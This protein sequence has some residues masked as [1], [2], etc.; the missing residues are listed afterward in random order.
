MFVSFAYGVSLRRLLRYSLMLLSLVAITSGSSQAEPAAPLLEMHYFWGDGCPYCA[1]QDRWLEDIERHYPQLVVH[2][3]EVWNNRANLQLFQQFAATRGMEARGVP[4]TF[5]GSEVWIGFSEQIADEMETSIR[6]RL[7]AAEQGVLETDEEPAALG[8]ASQQLSLPWIG[9]VNLQ[10]QSLWLMTG[11]IAFV[12]GFNPCSLWVLTLLLAMVLHSGSRRKTFIVGFTFLFVTAL[13]YGLFVAGLV[14][15]LA[16]A[17]YLGWLQA[18]VALVALAFAA[19]NI[20]DYFYYKQGISLTIPERFKPGIYKRMR[21]AISAKKSLPATI[22][23]TAA[24]ASVVTLIELPCTAGF[25]VIWGNILASQQV[26]GTTFMGL[27]GLYMLV[28]LLDELLVFVTVV[29]T[30]KASR[31]EE[32]HGRALKLIGGMVMLALAIT[33]LA[34]PHLMDS[35]LG[36]L[37]IFGAAL[38]A[39]LLI[40]AIDSWRL[41]YQTTS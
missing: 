29:L 25:P 6:R 7:A 9:T 20:K 21:H 17:S 16:Y 13:L 38:G 19:I 2:R 18:V 24:L 39:A 28:Y 12:D 34:A 35:V 33:M 8:S 3:Y 15:A 23:A 27:L 14:N 1:L 37:L 41:R 36:A 5:L 30:L 11:L 32:K 10:A 31:L 4:A 22:G 40:M 26:S